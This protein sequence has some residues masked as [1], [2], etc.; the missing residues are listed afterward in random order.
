MQLKTKQEEYW[1][2]EFGDQYNVRN[3]EKHMESRIE[4]FK[5]FPPVSSVYEPGAGSG[6]NLE[7]I[8]RVSGAMEFSATEINKNAYEQLQEKPYVSAQMG[9]ILEEAPFRAQL[10]LTYGLLIAI[11][12]DY[13]QDAYRHLY[14]ASQQYILLCEYY[15]STP[16]EIPYHGKANMLWKRDFAGDML[17]SFDLKL[18]DYGFV[19]H[20]DPYPMGD[21]SWFLLEK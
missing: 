18:R 8:H 13:L 10:V 20:R 11:N 19:Y 6:I 2:N 12:P 14:E 3:K 15:N 1:A 16:V 17:D 7:A 5:K 21:I 4:F 9:S